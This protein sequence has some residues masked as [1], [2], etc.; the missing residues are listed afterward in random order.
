MCRPDGV[1][2]SAQDLPALAVSHV[3]L[4]DA[5][6]R[7]GGV[8]EPTVEALA[9]DL[10]EL[11]LLGVGCDVDHRA[12]RCCA[13]DAVH[14]GHVLLGNVLVVDDHLLGTATP[15]LAQVTFCVDKDL[16]G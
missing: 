10:H 13:R 8:E 4:C 7:L 6:A 2:G 1:E 11:V 15:D 5:L 12:Q 14:D 9:D 3:V 16:S